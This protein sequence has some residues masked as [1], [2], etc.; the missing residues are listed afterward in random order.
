MEWPDKY[1]IMYEQ[2]I[3]DLM[4]DGVAHLAAEWVAEILIRKKV[5][6]LCLSPLPNFIE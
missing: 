5:E 4:L 6:K 2:M 1:W 3:H